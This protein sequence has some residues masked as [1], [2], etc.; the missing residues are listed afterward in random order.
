MR[1]L[2]ISVLAVFA[3]LSFTPFILIAK[4]KPDYKSLVTKNERSEFDVKGAL[5]I[6]HVKARE[7]HKKGVVFVDVRRKVQYKLAHIPGAI[8]LE[9]HSMLT[10]ANLAKHVAKDEMVV[11]YCSDHKCYRSAHASAKAITW[12]YTKVVYFAGGW[13]FWYG[14]GNANR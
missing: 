5:K 12:G 8:N 13:T 3:I 2:L 6:D 10:E 14:G 1:K 9:L 7:L 4:E 11:F